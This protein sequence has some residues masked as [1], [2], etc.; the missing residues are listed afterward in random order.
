VSLKMLHLA[1]PDTTEGCSV[2]IKI[3]IRKLG[4]DVVKPGVTPDTTA[5]EKPVVGRSSLETPVVSPIQ[6]VI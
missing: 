1:I 5:F 4:A 2:T 6:L 3:C